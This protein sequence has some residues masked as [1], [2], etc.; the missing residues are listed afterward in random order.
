MPRTVV[1]QTLEL[2]D[3]NPSVNELFRQFDKKFFYNK[4]TIKTN[5]LGN[6]QLKWDSSMATWVYKC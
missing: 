1:D 3:P 6:V 2:I 5:R 4:L